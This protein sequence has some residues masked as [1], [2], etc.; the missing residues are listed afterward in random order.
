MAQTLH[1][2]G[3]PAMTPTTLAETLAELHPL[4]GDCRARLASLFGYASETS[5]RN[6]LAGKQRVPDD[7]A[8]FL[9][10]L[11]TVMRR[12]EVPPPR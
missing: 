6:M 1:C 7:L 10:D 11:R 12:H 9:T 8:W 3:D 2:L 4:L 5:I